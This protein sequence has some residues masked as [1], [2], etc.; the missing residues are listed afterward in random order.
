MCTWWYTHCAIHIVLITR[1]CIEA[2]RYY[3]PHLLSCSH[4]N[5]IIND[6]GRDVL[7]SM[8]VIDG[9]YHPPHPL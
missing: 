2:L 1:M 3:T 4:R 6:I 9:Y 8:H 7:Y 5:L